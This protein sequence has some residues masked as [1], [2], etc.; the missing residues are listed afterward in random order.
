MTEITIAS[1]RRSRIVAFAI[2]ALVALAL[3]AFATGCS[4]TTIANRDPVG[5]AFPEV[6]GKALDDKQWLIPQDL[7]GKPAILLIGMVQDSQFDIDRW[8]LGIA[9]TETPVPFLELPTIKGLAPR[10]FKGKI[11]D[12][13]RGGIPVED[14][15]G[16][17]TL[18]GDDAGRVVELTGN[19]RPRSARVI[20]L[21]AEGRVAWFADHGFSAGGMIDL[22]ARAR[23]LLAS[24]PSVTAPT[25]PLGPA[26]PAGEDLPLL[27]GGGR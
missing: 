24:A 25:P 12:G 10:M 11:D 26:D 20:L 5:E 2:L 6:A 23:E 16:V 17:I 7:A 21:D 4:S 3:V 13:M 9:Q 14:W 15:R 22:D 27:K 18:W 1:R 8:L 19:E